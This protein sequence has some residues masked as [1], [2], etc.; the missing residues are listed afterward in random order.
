MAT[1]LFD[2]FPSA[3]DRVSFA[4]GQTTWDGFGPSEAIMLRAYTSTSLL[5]VIVMR[6]RERTRSRMRE[7][8]PA[9]REIPDTDYDLFIYEGRDRKTGRPYYHWRVSRRGDGEQYF[10]TSRPSH[11]LQMVRVLQYAA[12]G[13]SRI[14]GGG[15]DLE[16]REKLA[17]LALALQSVSLAG[18]DGLK[19]KVNGLGDVFGNAA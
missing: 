3:T 15:I 18:D 4:E 16:L 10:S 1:R 2:R 6:D 11:L 17:A 14:E 5:V 7:N 19:Q 8:E 12:I 13:F 9:V